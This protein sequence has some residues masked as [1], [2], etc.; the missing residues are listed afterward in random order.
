MP[1]FDYKVSIN[2]NQTQIMYRYI[3][4]N[5]QWLK[6]SWQVQEIEMQIT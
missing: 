3:V 5:W 1:D 2:I 6:L 4:S